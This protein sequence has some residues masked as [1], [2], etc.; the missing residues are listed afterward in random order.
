MAKSTVTEFTQDVAITD[1][2]GKPTTDFLQKLNGVMRTL[3][4][5]KGSLT[6]SKA[7]LVQITS[8][9]WTIPA[10]EDD[11]T[12]IIQ[13]APGAFTIT[14]VTTITKAGTATV[15]ITIN[16]TPLGG[17]ANSASTT[18][19]S[20]AHSSAN[21]VAA[22]D[23]VAIVVSSTSSCEMLTVDIAGTVTLST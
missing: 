6:T 2:S 3:T 14:E 5:T 17:T 21:A 13:K 22:G 1:S 20:Q 4:G 19:Q 15:T 11:S 18:E 10:P 23:T 16:G 8:G 12:T 9:H 7:G